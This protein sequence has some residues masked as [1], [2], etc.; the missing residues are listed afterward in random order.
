MDFLEIGSDDLRIEVSQYGAALARVWFSDIAT[1]LVLGLPQPQDY[2]DAPH[3]IG[4]IVGPIAGRIANAKVVLDGTTFHLDE[5]TPPDCLHSG[6]AGLQHQ[7]WDVKEHTIDRLTLECK[8]SDGTCGLPGNRVFSAQYVVTGTAITL[9]LD[10]TTDADTY[11]NATSHAY[12]VLDTSGSLSAHKMSI[13]ADGFI[14]AGSD[15]IPTGRIVPVAATSMDYSTARCPVLG[16]PLDNTFCLTSEHALDMF[17]AA[18]SVRLQ[19]ETNQPG[20]VLYTGEHLPEIRGG[21]DTPIIK[22]FSAIAIEAQGWPDAPNHAQFPSIEL[23]KGDH[24][25]QITHFKL[26]KT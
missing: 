22:P 17:S 21:H 18:S 16:A 15:L 1:S 13:A 4:V 26:S 19:V 9:T 2:A 24:L 3:A 10:S 6:P 23:R 20:M 8:L 11:V 14:E 5:N 7:I 12:W 25:K